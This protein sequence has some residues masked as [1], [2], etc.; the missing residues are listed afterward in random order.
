M[1][2]DLKTL[3]AQGAPVIADGAMGSLLLAEGLPVGSPSPLWNIER[4]DIV[5]GIHRAYI[6]AGAQVIL[7]NSFTASRP[8]L[9]RAGLAARVGELNRAAADNARAE[10]DASENPVVV[11]GSMGPLGELMAPL[12]TLSPEQAR[13]YFAE[14]A[15]ALATGGVDV[16]WI[17]TMSAL[18][19]VQAAVE[20]C[21]DAAPQVPIVAT[22][23]F[24]RKGRTMMG[25]TP[26][27]ALERL[28]E[29]GLLAMGANC[30]NGT[31]EIEGVIQAMRAVD[32]DVP[33]V[34]KS[35]AGLPRLVDGMSVYDASP[36]DMAAYARTAH[37]L[38]AQIIGA[39]CGSTPAH[40]R[41]IA[42]AVK[43]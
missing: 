38:G 40:I 21:R 4:L 42:E 20:G 25:V 15:L 7:T 35:N 17:E 43:G 11:S 32:Q 37:Q 9:E 2:A 6:S 3:L 5:R 30:G 34:A 31:A 24:E 39:C 1:K 27:L 14:Q 12:G 28:R 36:D 10:A 33:L 8:A 19:E 29:L 23:T 18:E 16:F 13:S 22:M 41:A 26:A